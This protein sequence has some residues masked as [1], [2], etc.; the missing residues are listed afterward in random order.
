MPRLQLWYVPL[1]KFIRVAGLLAALLIATATLSAQDAPATTPHGL[2]LYAVE[3]P[4]RDRY[5][6]GRE[7][8][9]VDVAP[10]TVVPSGPFAVGERK[11]FFVT[12]SGTS[13]ILEVE[14]ELRGLGES[15]Y[16]WV[17]VGA[18]VNNADIDALV[19]AFDGRIYPK[20]RALWGSEA[21]PGIDGDPRVHTLFTSQISPGLLGYFSSD[22]TYPP[23][24]V[25]AS[26]A[27]E[28]FFMNASALGGVGALSDVEST[29][30]HEFQHMIRNNLNANSDT[31]LNEGL[32]MFTQVYMGYS[33][34]LFYANEFALSP[35]TPFNTWA[36]D[37][38]SSLPYYGSSMLFLT[39]LYER[40]GFDAL[41]AISQSD[42]R[43]MLAV[44]QAL[45]TYGGTTVDEFFADWVIATLL[46]DATLADGR[47]DYALI[48]FNRPARSSTY[49][50]YPAVSESAL[51][52]YGTRYFE[53]RD[54][55]ANGTLTLT[56]DAATSARLLPTDTASGQ[57]MWYSNR[58]D[59]SAKTLTRAFDLTGVSA[60]VLE[61]SVWYD[62][63]PLWDYA[64]LMVSTDQGATW[65]T[66]DTPL[67]TRDDPHGTSYG[68]GYTGRS[69]GWL[70][71]SVPLTDYAGQQIL[72]RFALI[73][74]DATNHYG[75]ALDDIRLGDA[76]FDDVE[77]GESGWE[78]AGWVRID[79]V[80]PQRFWLQVA[81][82]RGDTLTLD[83]VLWPSQTALRVPVLSGV[84][85][86]Y[87]A[88]SPIAP[89]TTV[90]ARYRLEIK[91]E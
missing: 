38:E 22:N 52:Q 67:T 39:Y 87:V 25:T 48:D 15:I 30:A 85:R 11:T 42:Q 77:A 63:E 14:A 23:E 41:H 34:S 79:N 72:V 16:V 13:R 46:Q 70:R 35:Y 36:T 45:A 86:A 76:F 18:R 89:Y 57:F 75:M 40:L 9:G 6:L 68:A 88:L 71:E 28:M 2:D 56:L 74:D 64:Y 27:H 58:A 62:I 37:S 1:T 60:P 32:S 31:W 44:E 20:V 84:E 90:P 29:L 19:S 43:A 4:A 54:L 33:D 73:T 5:A 65:R 91:A 55:P 7:L 12:D 80:L 69:N 17:D 81:Q 66:L 26:N 3:I 78:A 24:L 59:D 82:V 8:L 53:L 21:S 51:P 61:F 49:N 50:R 47:Y 10:G 83:R